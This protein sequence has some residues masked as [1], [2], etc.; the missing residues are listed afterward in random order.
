MTDTNYTFEAGVEDAGKRLDNVVYSFIS[1][2]DPGISRSRL[3][4]LIEEGLIL[5]N[6][7]PVKPSRKLKEGDC[8]S[9]I[10]PAPTELKAEPSDIPLDIM[11]EDDDILIVNKPKNMPV[12][13]GAGHYDN[14]LVNAVLFHCKGSL[15]GI[16]GVLRPGIV[17]RIDMDT[18]GSL[19]VCKNDNAHIHIA[20]QLEEHSI[21]REYEA[22][23]LGHF[24][25]GAN[26]NKGINRGSCVKYS[27]DP[28]LQKG[29][30]DSPISRDPGNRKRMCAGR[31]DGKK[32]ITHF[33]VIGE[34][35]PFSHIKCRLE[36]GRTHQ[37]RVHMALLSHP[38][39]GDEVYGGVIKPSKRYPV[40]PV[41][42]CGQCLHAKIIGFIHP[43]TGEYME[44]DAKRPRYFQ[45]LLGFLET[46]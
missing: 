2:R 3:Q 34:Y 4:S 17:H 18:T 46:L 7:L 44:F 29:S 38:V 33:E 35:G 23:V 28:V 27:Y 26:I 45:E 24:T 25:E 43:T 11:Y 8:I 41:D 10:V 1:E 22:V 19:I 21:K 16:N 37:I 5:I 9:I 13:P 42:L 20:R 31:K 15:S 40:L 12:H 6:K 30:V 36:T 32:A 14:T 39:L